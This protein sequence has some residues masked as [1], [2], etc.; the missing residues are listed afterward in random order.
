M[1]WAIGFDDTWRRDVGYGVPA[2]CD[3]T[4]CSTDIDRGLSFVCGG[5]AYGG[6]RGC[7]LFFCSKHLDHR[8]LCSR[9]RRGKAPFEPK[10]EHPRWLA[11]KLTDASWSEWRD[12]NPRAVSK[13]RRML[14]PVGLAVLDAVARRGSPDGW[15]PIETAPRDGSVIN[16]WLADADQ[17]D[18][19]FYCVHGTRF[20]SGWAFAN[21]KFRPIGGLPGIPVQ[22][23]PTHWMPVPEGPQ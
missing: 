6:S 22:V 13:L 20:S 4:E 23:Q 14:D 3:F 12:R 19:A 16:V 9:C 7:G 2:Y 5:E 10:R 8:H 18:A 21:G 11:H 15:R 1:S 17:D